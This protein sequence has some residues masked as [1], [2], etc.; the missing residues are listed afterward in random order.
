MTNSLQLYASDTANG[1]KATVV[2][3]E[4]QLD[5]D[6]RMIDLI[7]G[8]H[9]SDEYLA[10]NPVGR[11]PT[12]IDRRA[13]PEVSVYGTLAIGLHL[14]QDSRL[15]PADA[16]TRARMF[17]ALALVG[18]DLAPALSAQFMLAVI[19]DEKPP[20]AIEYFVNECRRFLAQLERWTEEREY[21]AGDQFSLA[22]ALTYPNIAVSCERIVP[23][24]EAY[25]SLRRWRD[26]VGARPGVTRGMQRLAAETS[27]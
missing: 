11:I 5:Y 9:R 10:V 18:T 4:L 20:G 23:G 22:D 2:L 8:E 25:P 14:A 12:L 15:I 16:A 6:V 19:L 3:E 7:K 27:V 13:D 1:Q 17:E 21:L 26:Q 24:L